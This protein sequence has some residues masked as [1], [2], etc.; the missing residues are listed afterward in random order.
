[1]KKEWL[2]V[3]GSVLITLIIALG[4]IRWLAPGLLGIPPDLQLVQVDK[5]IPPF[6]DNIFRLEDYA[7]KDF[8]INDPNTIQRAKPLFPDVFTL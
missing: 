4:W 3:L 2:L 8:I 1:M 7:S 5:R 6:Y